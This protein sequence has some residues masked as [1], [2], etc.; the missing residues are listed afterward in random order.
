MNDAEAFRDALEHVV[1]LLVEAPVNVSV[2]Y[3]DGP[4]GTLFVVRAD[5]RDVGR[6]LGRNRERA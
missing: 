1:K 2:E 6:V 3:T 5:P 4:A